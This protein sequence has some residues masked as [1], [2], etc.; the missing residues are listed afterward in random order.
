MNGS[1]LLLAQGASR[2]SYE[3]ARTQQYAERWHWLALVAVALAIVGWV[4]YLYRRDSVEL[5]PAARFLLLGLRLVALAG[6]LLYYLD[7]QKRDQKQVVHPSRVLV[8]IDTSTSMGLRDSDSS[9]PQSQSRLEKVVAVLDKGRLVERLREKHEVVLA[10]FD[11]DLGRLA[12][13]GKLPAQPAA[14]SR[15]AAAPTAAT[16]ADWAKPLA[17]RGGETRLAQAISQLLQEERGT[18]IAGLVVLTD[19]GQ[20]AGIEPAAAVEAALAAKVPIFPVGVGSDKRPANVRV[21][22][23]AAPARAYPGDSFAITGYLRAQELADRTV[24]VELVST[25]AGGA[26]QGKLEGTQRVT[27]GSDADVLPV[28]FE[29][30]PGEP[31]RRT[32]RLAVKAPS[33]DSDATDNRQEADVEIVDRKTRVLLVADGPL[34]DYIYLRNL[35]HR[36]RDTLVDVWLQIAQPGISQDAHEILDDFPS[37]PAELFQYDCIVAFDPDWTKLS[38]EQ[39]DLLERWVGENAGGLIL[40]AGPVNTGRWVGNPQLAKVQA[41]YPVEFFRRLTALSDERYGSE[42]PWPVEL[43]RE[44]MEAEFLWLGDDASSS[45]TRWAEFP[46][47]YGYYATKGPKSGATVLAHFSDPE[48]GSGDRRPVY[49]AGQFYGSGRVFYMAS[50]ELWR[51]RAIDEG[52]FEQLYTKLVRHVSQGRLLLGSSRGILLA[53]RDK[54]SLGSTVALRAQLTNAQFQPLEAPGV[55]LQVSEP[56]GAVATVQLAADPARKGQFLGQLTALKPGPYALELVVPES[57][58]ERLSRRFQVTVPQREQEDPRRNDAL[59]AELARRTR[60]TYTIGVEKALGAP[61]ARPLADELK[62]RT[63]VSFLAGVPD[64]DFNRRWMTVLLSVICGALCLEWLLRRLM[65]LA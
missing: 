4:A 61:G 2:V 53:D 28:K 19:G 12:T 47:V 13:L 18:P 64:V 60:G 41:L 9:V 46:G 44:G 22:D 36:D 30:T 38:A 42:T 6:A 63:E 49:F 51:L 45:Q 7:L 11:A 54:V 16:P 59:L 56:D 52:Y 57:N 20:N 34:R 40:V 23:L 65:K 1:P 31:G 14:A 29:V 27:L 3:W 35:L 25:P 55:A 39:V 32:F 33:E 17:P 8:L 10:R 26:G 50:G 37:T 5:R 48:S 58:D 21:A 24:T 43:T 62:D 15:S